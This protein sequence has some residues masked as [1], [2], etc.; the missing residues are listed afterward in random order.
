VISTPKNGVNNLTIKQELV[1]QHST[2]KLKTGT[3]NTSNYHSQQASFNIK[4]TPGG[5]LKNKHLILAGGNSYVNTDSSVP[6]VIQTTNPINLS[7]KNSNEK[8]I[9][10]A[11]FNKHTPTSKNNNNFI[12]NNTTN[13][14]I[15]NSK[16]ILTDGDKKKLPVEDKSKRMTPKKSTNTIN[17]NLNTSVNPQNNHPNQN[18][19]LNISSLIKTKMTQQST[20][21]NQGPLSSVPMTKYHSKTNSKSSSR[22][23][24]KSENNKKI[25]CEVKKTDINLIGKQSQTKTSSLQS[26]INNSKN[27]STNQFKKHATTTNSPKHTLN[28]NF[29]KEIAKKNIHN[30]MVGKPSKQV[31]SLKLNLNNLNQK[32]VTLKEKNILKEK[33]NINTSELNQ[34][35]LSIDNI[36]ET[37]NCSVKSSLRESNYYKKESEKISNY[38][39]MYYNKHNEYPPTN[40]KHYKYG[41]LIGKGAFGKVNLGLHTLTGRRVAIKSFNKKHLTNENA[42]KKIYYETNLM[43]NL[44][45]NSIVRYL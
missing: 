32:E 13:N 42:K 39:K 24:D 34:N 4:D 9:N 45:H 38:I 18:A 30:N 16:I 22:I 41:R 27:N 43:K 29:N 37:S 14:N 7:R 21:I 26:T 33:T 28:I 15:N 11:H 20:N 25:E 23:E 36:L 5:N 6:P 10:F 12:N 1:K 31:L 3:T 2:S 44:K 19:K 40:L 17:T 35:N 8:R